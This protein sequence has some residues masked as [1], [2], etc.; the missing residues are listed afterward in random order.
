M[1][2][3]LGLSEV[4]A[5][6]SMCSCLDPALLSKLTAAIS[7]LYDALCTWFKNVRCSLQHAFPVTLHRHMGRTTRWLAV[8]VVDKSAC[9]GPAAIRLL[10]YIPL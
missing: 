1:W 10:P 6:L 3:T 4:K 9:K 5:S 8:T 2:Y 7:L